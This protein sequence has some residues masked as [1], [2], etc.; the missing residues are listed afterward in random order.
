MIALE[1]LIS[2]SGGR[3]HAA[4]LARLSRVVAADLIRK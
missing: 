1:N 3:R 4:A 2:V